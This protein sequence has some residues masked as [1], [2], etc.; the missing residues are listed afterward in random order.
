MRHRLYLKVSGFLARQMAPPWGSGGPFSIWH[1]KSM[2]Q[3]QRHVR[4]GFI[5]R[6]YHGASVPASYGDVEAEYAAAMRGC[7]LADLSVFG[8]IEVRGKD[9]LDLLH[10]LSTNDL[11]GARK[12]EVRSTVFLTD[13]G[14]IVDRALL[15]VRED[16][17][18][19]VTSPGAEDLLMEWLAKY[20]ITE[21]ITLTNV[22]DSTAMFCILGPALDSFAYQLDGSLP[23]ENCWVLWPAGGNGAMLTVRTEARQRY[24][25]MTPSSEQ[26]ASAWPALLRAG[27]GAGCRPIGSIAYE[28]YR[29]SRGVAARPGELSDARNP[30]DAGL[31]E[32]ISFTKGCYI[33]Q[34]VVAR[35]DTYQKVRKGLAGIVFSESAPGVPGQALL[36]GGEEVGELTSALSVR[37][38]GK[39]PGLAVVADAVAH[40][41]DE[42]IAA[43]SGARGTITAFPINGAGS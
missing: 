33:G 18:L 12:G 41:G 34:E 6:P 10:R 43:D 23:A 29:I 7:A 32:D 11:L 28:A 25:L 20:T 26:A 30:Y 13:K 21:D 38:M 35:L 9:R 17:L 16:S 27:E 39:F 5:T 15:M 2:S 1:R 37:V 19:M 24:A 22:T 3:D 42:L 4:E 36:K 31:R 14:R 8:R 40:P